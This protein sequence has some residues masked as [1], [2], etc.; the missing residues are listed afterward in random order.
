MLASGCGDAATFACETATDCGP[1]GACESTGFCSFPDAACPSRRRYG[2]HAD[3]ALSG[4]CVPIEIAA[5]GESTGGVGSSATSMVASSETLTPT[6]GASSSG[7]A[8]GTSNTPATETTV[9]FATSSSDSSSST[10]TVERV[11]G[12]LLVLYRFDEGAGTVAS[13][14][15]GVDPPV[16]LTIEP[17]LGS[18]SWVDGGLAFTG[19]GIAR[20]LGSATKIRT[21]CQASDELSVEA[22]V[23][24]TEASQMGPARIATLSEDAGS[25][26]FTLAHSVN[27]AAE[28]I[29]IARLT[30]STS[31]QNGTPS[32]AAQTLATTN[33]THLLF[34]RDA[35]GVVTFWVDA[36][37]SLSDTR[38]G[39]FS[40]WLATDQ[41]AVG[42]EI[43]LDRPWLGVIHLI[44]VYDRALTPDE[45][46]QNFAAGL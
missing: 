38:G 45:V 6:S 1:A 17:Q 24:A 12:G 26:S 44:A 43:S 39:D 7:S 15:S 36:E 2:E 22:W 11:V 4:T 10:G 28:P 31:D 25:R 41:F 42:N 29:W 34:S 19:A 16:D 46:A 33:T 21:A 8:D 40:T 13:D 35:D 23:T 37:L 5:S 18:P 30:T 20:A 3:S 27:V 32:F 9:G 14:Q